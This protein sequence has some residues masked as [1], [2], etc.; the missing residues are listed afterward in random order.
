MPWAPE[1]EAGAGVGAGIP[2]CPGRPE[3][4]AL[5]VPEDELLELEGEGMLELEAEGEDEAD[6]EPLLLDGDCDEDELEL[7]LELLDEEELELLLEELELLLDEV[8]HAA[9]NA[10]MATTVK[11]LIINNF[12]PRQPLL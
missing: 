6:G 3:A 5:G 8:W 11:F 12:S 9:S 10:A 4:D 1:D 7:L 2:L